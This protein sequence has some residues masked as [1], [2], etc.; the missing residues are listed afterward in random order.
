MSPTNEPGDIIHSETMFPNRSSTGPDLSDCPVNFTTMYYAS[1]YFIPNE[2]VN[3][4]VVATYES[5]KAGMI[6]FE[7]GYGTVFLSSPHP[8]YEENSDRDD[9]SEFDYLDDPD[10]EWNFL[11][12]I[13]QWL[14]EA[15]SDPPPKTETAITSSESSTTTNT[16]SSLDIQVIGFATTGVVMLVLVVAILSRRMHH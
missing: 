2:G 7:Y 3:V 11:L 6:A 4:H 1:Q 8:E 13:S 12:K 16:D 5:G 15:S 14:V 9:T 10:S